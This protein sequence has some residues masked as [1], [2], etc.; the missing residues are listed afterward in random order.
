V[1]VRVLFVRVHEETMALHRLFFS[2]LLLLLLFGS[3]VHGSDLFVA[4]NATQLAAINQFVALLYAQFFITVYPQFCPTTPSSALKFACANDGSVTHINW[5]DLRL[6]KQL[7]E[8]TA[9]LLSQLP[10]LVYLNL[11]NNGLTGDVSI[12]GASASLLTL[13]VSR[14]KLSGNALAY[15]A[16][17]LPALATCVLQDLSSAAQA[18][19][20]FSP[21]ATSEQT[22][23]NPNHFSPLPLCNESFPAIT[24]TAAPA[25]IIATTEESES[26]SEREVLANA[27]AKDISAADETSSQLN[28]KQQG[29][30]STLSTASTIGLALAAPLVLCIGIGVALYIARKRRSRVE[31]L[32][33]GRTTIGYGA[34]VDIDSVPT[35]EDRDVGESSGGANAELQAMSPQLRDAQIEAARF[36]TDATMPA[37]RGSSQTSRPHYV[38]AGY[39]AQQ[40]FADDTLRAHQL[41]FVKSGDG[42]RRDSSSE[43]SH[44]RFPQDEFEEQEQAIVGMVSAGSANSPNNK[45]EAEGRLAEVRSLVVPGLPGLNPTPQYD[46]FPPAA[47][48]SPSSVGDGDS[49][50]VDMDLSQTTRRPVDTTKRGFDER[51]LRQRRPN[52]NNMNEALSDAV[53][54]KKNKNGNN[55]NN[56]YANPQDTLAY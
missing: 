11:S 17:S 32:S 47:Q 24:A 40:G 20:C 30:H 29:A 48:H 34:A 33:A 31:W 7:P 2:L 16:A 35:D 8:Q 56:N 38:P 37:S 28:N 13:D 3:T 22:L 21:S 6:N 43:Y 19:N 18:T 53:S 44:I 36:L 41:Q 14:N 4:F 5:P 25:T 54:S 10:A 15:V 46:R 23:C 49:T 42:T 50:V 27:P 12:I 39:L 45:S 51:S 52:Y 26:S 9:S 55:D 1:F